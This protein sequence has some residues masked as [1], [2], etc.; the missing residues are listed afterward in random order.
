MC[1]RDRTNPN[2]LVG[3]VIVKDGRII[4]VSYT[5]LVGKWCDGDICIIWEFASPMLSGIT[6]SSSIS[7]A[8]TLTPN[9]RY[10]FTIFLEL[11]FSSP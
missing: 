10:I 8:L 7:S 3:A 1:I 9:E 11:G 5:H 4:A 2:P 6:P